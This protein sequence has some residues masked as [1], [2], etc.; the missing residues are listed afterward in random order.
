M[1]VS[2]LQPKQYGLAPINTS[3]RR[4]YST[5]STVKS[6]IINNNK[7]ECTTNTTDL[8]S[9]ATHTGDNLSP[10][11]ITGITDAEGSFSCIIKRNMASRLK[12]RVEVVFQIVLHT[13]DLKLL[14]QIK[15]Y[16]DGVGIITKSEA[17]SMCAFRVTSLKQIT[18][19]I[20]PHFALYPL[21]TQKGADFQLWLD[22][23]NIMLN[24]KSLTE[25]DLKNIVNIR[26]SLN[27]GLSEVL[28]AAF[29]DYIPVSRPSLSI[30][31][32]LLHPEWMAGFTTGEGCF[33]VKVN[34]GRNKCGV[35]VQLVFQL[36]Q[37]LRDEL[38][39]ESFVTYFNCGRLVRVVENHWGYFQ[40]TK[41]S[42]NYDII[43]EFFKKHPIRGEKGKDFA[44][45]IRVAEII[46]SGGHLTPEG[47]KEIMQI[48]SGMNTGRSIDL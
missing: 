17:K 37:H 26:A 8:S 22:I 45:W 18:K 5:S 35:G 27:L 13:K 15:A 36:A 19:V 12:W 32:E 42:D 39:L 21:K 48:K 6:D 30:T 41:F 47:S 11:F 1:V 24:A 2:R 10:W 20:L 33:F 25:N 44:D 7:K 29:P 23:V 46:K 4:R 3:Y 31:Q 14:E 9:S 16:F 40:S 28:K 38:L 34:K 43:I